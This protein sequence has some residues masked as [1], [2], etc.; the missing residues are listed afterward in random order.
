ML[1]RL[2]STGSWTS[3][4]SPFSLWIAWWVFVVLMSQVAWKSDT[5]LDL[6]WYNLRYHVNI[7][8]MKE[9][10]IITV[11]SLPRWHWYEGQLPC[12]GF[13]WLATRLQQTASFESPTCWLLLPKSPMLL[14]FQFWSFIKFSKTC[15]AANCFAVTPSTEKMV[16]KCLFLIL[17]NILSLQESWSLVGVSVLVTSGGNSTVPHDMPKV[18]SKRPS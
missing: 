4:Q 2:C 17:S 8:S 12:F 6:N 16:A 15:A 9:R 13:S 3:K 5:N 1:T 14:I 7:I 11:V 18:S 10:G